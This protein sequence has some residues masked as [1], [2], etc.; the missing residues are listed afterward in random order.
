MGIAQ[1]LLRIVV[2]LFGALMLFVASQYV[3]DPEVP[4]RTLGLVGEGTL[5]RA[6]LRADLG[7]FFGTIG[8]FCLAAAALNKRRLMTAPV[9]LIAIALAGR[10]LTVL[11]DG[12]S[13]GDL[14]PVGAEAVFLA[15]FL[16]GR[17]GLAADGRLGNQ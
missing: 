11:L 15:V 16:T 14:V 4:A 1:I 3:I 8:I 2:A 7:A 6:S 5:G 9:L 17:F 10:I 12:Q 13:E